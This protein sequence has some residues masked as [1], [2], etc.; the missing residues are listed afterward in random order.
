MRRSTAIISLVIWILFFAMHLWGQAELKVTDATSQQI[1]QEVI[2]TKIIADGEQIAVGESRGPQQPPVIRTI[3]LITIKSINETDSV[4]MRFRDRAWN[5]VSERFVDFGENR[6]GISQTGDYMIEAWIR[7]AQTGWIKDIVEARVTV[8]PGPGPNPDPDDPDPDPDPSGPFDGIAAKVRTASQG[9][10]R[11][12]AYGQ[13]FADVAQRMHSFEYLQIEQA[14]DEISS[15]RKQFDPEYQNVYKVIL[16]DS[17]GRKLNW[18]DSIAWYT[19]V[20]KGLGVQV[21]LIRRIPASKQM[22]IVPPKPIRY[23]I[24]PQPIPMRPPIIL[25]RWPQPSEPFFG[26]RCVGNT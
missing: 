25:P 17:R 21:N 26:L 16:E 13:I 3:K 11:N 7:D 9:L 5:D 15:R 12:A 2:I 20:A 24:I 19:E 8:G 14:R 1:T 23:A 22:Q 6:W 10:S 18:Q 4:T